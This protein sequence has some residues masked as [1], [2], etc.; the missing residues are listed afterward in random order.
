MLQQIDKAQKVIKSEAVAALSESIEIL[1]DT[2][3]EFYQLHLDQQATASTAQESLKEEL[4]KLIDHF[5]DQTPTDQDIC[6]RRLREYSG[7]FAA[8]KEKTM[9][10]AEAQRS[11]WEGKC[12]LLPHKIR[13]ALI[14]EYEQLCQQLRGPIY[15][16][17]RGLC[18]LFADTV[19]RLK[20]IMNQV[21]QQ[22]VETMKSEHDSL[23][24]NDTGTMMDML[25]VAQDEIDLTGDDALESPTQFSVGAV[26]FAKIHQTKAR[27]EFKSGKVA[28]L[29]GDGTYTMSFD[30]GHT[31]TV[32]AADLFTKE[33]V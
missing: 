33:Q 9:K 13:V 20:T 18:V 2:S 25:H 28:E 24:D 3:L 17:L 12:R 11:L 29:L 1:M 6:E 32:S 10:V 7:I 15:E 4:D 21:M 5:G 23:T 31:S 19:C 26:V 30:D 27:S 14:E 22:L 16:V 8:S